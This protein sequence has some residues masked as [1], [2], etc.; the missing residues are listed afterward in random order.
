ML[1]PIVIQQWL[2]LYLFSRGVGGI[3]AE[4]VMLSANIYAIPEA[5]GVRLSGHLKDGLTATDLVLN[6]TENLEIW[7]L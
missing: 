2:M 3:E 6:I 5:V 1:E 4:A 7:M